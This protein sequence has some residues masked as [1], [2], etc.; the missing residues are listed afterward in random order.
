V[1]TTG[2]DV[3]SH[4][5]YR[6]FL[7]DHFAFAQARGL[8]L[9]G[10]ARR[11]GIRSPSFLKSVMEGHKTIAEDTA[12]R[13]ARARRLEGNGALYF[14]RLVAF[15]QARG[16]DQKRAAYERMRAFADWRRIHALDIA[17]GFVGR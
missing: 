13:V 17:P 12:V 2:P 9:R 1:S 15:N 4:L 14:V 8:S 6:R 16:S 11:A 5:D 10:F 7:R 3:F